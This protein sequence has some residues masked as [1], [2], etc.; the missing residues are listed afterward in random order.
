M[1]VSRAIRA[2]PCRMIA[3]AFVLAV[4]VHGVDAAPA[5]GLLQRLEAR[6]IGMQQSA[7]QTTQAEAARQPPR[8]FSPDASAAVAPRV[9]TR[10]DLKI[11]REQIEKTESARLPPRQP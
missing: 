9:L 8:F 3:L 7:A 6:P 1:V 10:Q 5:A 11:L 4:G 2:H